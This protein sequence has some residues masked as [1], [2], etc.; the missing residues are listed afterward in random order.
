MVFDNVMIHIQFHFYKYI[1]TRISSQYSLILKKFHFQKLPT[2]GPMGPTLVPSSPSNYKTVKTKYAV[3]IK[4][5]YTLPDWIILYYF[6][7][8]LSPILALSNK[9]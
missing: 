6:Y 1:C 4:P 9:K 3:S 2:M 8:Y 7:C 5:E